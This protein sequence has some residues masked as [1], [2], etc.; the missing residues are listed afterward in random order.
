M[1]FSC[2]EHE[3]LESTVSVEHTKKNTIFDNVTDYVH[4]VKNGGAKSRSAAMNSIVPYMNNNGDTLAYIV[5][6]NEGWELLSNDR[7]TPLVL[8]SSNQGSFNLSEIKK[9]DN[10]NNYWSSME[11][12]L[13]ALKEKPI[14]ENDTL[15]T[16]WNA[17]YVENGSVSEENIVRTSE[18]Y[19]EVTPGE[20]GYW[21]VIESETKE[22][23]EVVSDRAIT[24]AWDKGMNDYIP[25]KVNSVGQTVHC[26]PG[27]VAIAGAQYLYYLHYK[28]NNPRY[29]VDTGVYDSTTGQ[30][31][32]S[33]SSETIWEQMNDILYGRY[34]ASI[35][36]GYVAKY[37]DTTFGINESSAEADLLQGLINSYG[38][39]LSWHS[40]SSSSIINIIKQHGAVISSI[41]G[42]YIGQTQDIGH[43]FIIDGY[44][45]HITETTTTYGWVGEDNRGMDTNLRDPEGNVIGYGFTTTETTRN[46]DNRI[47]MNWGLES[48]SHNHTSFAVDSY[49][50]VLGDITYYKDKKILY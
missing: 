30:Y 33:G 15:G 1:F 39:S 27:C 22:I 16:G 9:N 5:N 28:N 23:S 12:D 25:F 41:H 3:E 10:L 38:Y 20:N 37:V 19:A 49:S 26:A 8:V 34:Y 35:M 48:A 43:A 50:W 24:T 17:F 13:T 31:I 4:F 2:S 46:T 14:T 7:R 6:Y 47:Y 45:T 32:F 29:M 40:Y 11:N 18:V 42:N 21:E 44:K 36:V